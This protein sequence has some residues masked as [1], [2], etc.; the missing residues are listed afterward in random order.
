MKKVIFAL[1]VALVSTS[2]FAEKAES[3]V[4]AKALK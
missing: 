1:L 4:E 3:K 2:T